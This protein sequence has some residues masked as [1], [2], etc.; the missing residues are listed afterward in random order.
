MRVFDDHQ[1]RHQLGR[2]RGH[3]KQRGHHALLQLAR[4]QLARGQ[5][6]HGVALAGRQAQQ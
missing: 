6:E 2:A 3:R 4:G 5:V 1:Q